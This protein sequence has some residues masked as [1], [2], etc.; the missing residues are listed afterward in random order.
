[1]YVARKTQNATT[2]LLKFIS[3]FTFC[4]RKWKP[5]SSHAHDC[6]QQVVKHQELLPT[7]LTEIADFKST[8]RLA[9][10][11]NNTMDG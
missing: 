10:P 9:G 1:M 4:D 6:D 5:P 3:Y 11:G 2:E 7:A 8:I